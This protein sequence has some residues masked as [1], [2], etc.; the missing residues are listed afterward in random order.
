LGAIA[1]NKTVE[2][3]ENGVLVN[4]T[5]EKNEFFIMAW[6]AIVNYSYYKMLQI[7]KKLET[8]L[9]FWVDAFFLRGDSELQKA[10]ELI[11]ESK[12]TS[13]I[14]K[15][16]KMY[17]AEKVPE[18]TDLRIFNFT[19]KKENEPITYICLPDIRLYY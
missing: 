15:I 14:K 18:N 16:E 5:N 10:Q 6:K 4:I 3:Y 7:S 13:K 17:Y 19:V 9:L 11:K 12:Y 8:Y 1:T 2:T